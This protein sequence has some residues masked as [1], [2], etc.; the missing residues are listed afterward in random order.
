MQSQVSVLALRG[1]RLVGV[2]EVGGLAGGETIRAVRFIGPLGYV[3][4]FRQ[5]DPLYVVDLSRPKSPTVAGELKLPGYSAY[6]HPIGDGLLLGLGQNADADG[7]QLGLQLSLFDVT[8]PAD[9][10]R[11][12]RVACPVPTPTSRPTTTH[13]PTPAASR[14]RRTTTPTSTAAT[15][16]AS[17]PSRCTTTGSPHPS[18]CARTMRHPWTR[19]DA[20]ARGGRLR[21]HRHVRRGRGARRRNPRAGGLHTVL[22]PAPSRQ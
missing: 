6:L 20:H 14:S 9:P 15:T 8:D 3:V 16:V 4:T 2:G 1:D 5:T 18:R 10:R 22:R 13:S 21:L 19:T 17:W 7:R 11:L 12:D